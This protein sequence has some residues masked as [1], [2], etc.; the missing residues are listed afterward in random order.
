[1]INLDKIVSKYEGVSGFLLYASKAEQILVFSEVAQKSNE[2][3][4]KTFRE[5][6]SNFA[7]NEGEAPGYSVA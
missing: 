5:A 7:Q 2:D 6:R 3:Q 4:M 1:M